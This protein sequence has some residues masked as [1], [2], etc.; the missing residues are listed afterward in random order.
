ML[1]LLRNSTDYELKTET[2]YKKVIR[3]ITCADSDITCCNGK[4]FKYGRCL[5]KLYVLSSFNTVKPDL[6]AT[7]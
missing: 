5:R 2:V 6:I 1:F 4:I 3:E 7:I